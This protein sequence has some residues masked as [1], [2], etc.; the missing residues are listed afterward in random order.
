MSSFDTVSFKCPECGHYIEVQTKAGDCR[1]KEY[2]NLRVPAII[3]ASM[4]AE[5]VQCDCCKN[6]FVMASDIL[7]RYVPIMLLPVPVESNY[8]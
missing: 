3:A 5:K 8:D 1:M 4:N 6:T 7:P 2:A